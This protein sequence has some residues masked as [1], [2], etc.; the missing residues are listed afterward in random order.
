MRAPFFNLK[1]RL[2]IDNR[3][4]GEGVKWYTRNGFEQLH[5]HRTSP[6]NRELRKFKLG[7]VPKRP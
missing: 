1:T 2:Q 4:M 5:V 3:L 7:G 6:I